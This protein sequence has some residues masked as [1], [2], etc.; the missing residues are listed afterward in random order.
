MHNAGKEDH[1]LLV[2]SPPAACPSLIP[3]PTTSNRKVFSVPFLQSLSSSSL[4]FSAGAKLLPSPLRLNKNPLIL[5]LFFSNTSEWSVIFARIVRPSILCAPWQGNSFRRRL[6]RSLEQDSKINNL[7]STSWPILSSVTLFTS[8]F[9][10][11]P[12]TCIIMWTF[13]TGDSL[14]QSII[15]KHSK[16]FSNSNPEPPRSLPFAP[17]NKTHTS[18]IKVRTNSKPNKNINMSSLPVILYSLSME[19]ICRHYAESPCIYVGPFITQPPGRNKRQ[20]HAKTKTG[21]SPIKFAI[22]STLMVT[23][24]KG[25]SSLIRNI[26]PSFTITMGKNYLNISSNTGESFLPRKSF[27]SHTSSTF[28]P[29][30]TLSMRMTPCK[31]NCIANKRISQ[32]NAN[33]LMGKN[34]VKTSSSLNDGLLLRKLTLRPQNINYFLN[35]FVKHLLNTNKT[36][37]T[38]IKSRKTVL[39]TRTLKNKFTQPLINFLKHNQKHRVPELI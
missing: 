24:C 36:Q 7:C 27:G 5:L 22:A 30:R 31:G 39:T 20:K 6:V 29:T 35:T 25:N 12:K 21:R 13:N 11:G 15:G 2:W 33:T 17:L 1:R 4:V 37:E 28:K 19:S 26:K 3:L 23:P 9:H 10:R 18:T 32:Q 14:F 38:R 16:C 8:S 34:F